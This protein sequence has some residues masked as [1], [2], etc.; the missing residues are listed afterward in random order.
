MI[1]ARFMRFFY[2]LL[3]H[4]FAFAYDLVASLVSF[5]SWKDWV[6]S[7]LPFIEGTRVLEIGHGP[8]H[9]QRVLRDQNLIP[10]GLDE[11]TP[12]GNLAKARLRISG[13]KNINLARGLAQNLPFPDESFHTIVSTFPSEYIFD[14]RTLAEAGRCLI[15]GG[16][17]VVLPVV[18]PK[19]RLLNWLYQATGEATPNALQIVSE[20][21]GGPMEAAGFQVEIKT[22]ELKSSVLIYALARK[23]REKPGRDYFKI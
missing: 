2:D 16:R 11:S 17:F 18:W 22:A 20:K 8:G 7:I 3:Y 9:L 13:H 19:N 5:G 15:N 21:I 23:T 12:M 1:I 10:F 4:P 14:P 6:F